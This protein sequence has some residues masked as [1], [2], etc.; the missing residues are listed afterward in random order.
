MSKDPCRVAAYAFDVPCYFPM[1]AQ[2]VD[3]K[4]VFLEGK[5]RLATLYLPCGRCLGCRMERSRQWAIRCMHEA[6]LHAENCFITLTYSDEHLSGDV[7]SLHYPDFQLFMK[8]LRDRFRGTSIRFYMCGEYG[9]LKMRPH[10]H[11]LL[12]GFTFPDLVL[13]QKTKAGEFIYRS[14]IL[15]ELWP[16]GFSSVGNCTFQSAA[17][18][19][20]YVMKKQSG[21]RAEKHYARVDEKTGEV[22]TLV[23]EFNR[24]SLKPGIGAAWYEKHKHHVQAHDFLIVN[25]KKVKPPRYYDNKFKLEN[26]FDYDVMKQNRLDNFKKNPAPISSQLAIAQRQAGMLK[27]DLE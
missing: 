16:F 7:A 12:F 11:A 14:Q 17:Y 4:I 3:G 2:K 18:I 19:A 15:E 25:G 13:W 22:I 26:E 6:S 20:R 23:P 8:R 1:P 5:N 24:M 9:S 10:F 27:R 21:D